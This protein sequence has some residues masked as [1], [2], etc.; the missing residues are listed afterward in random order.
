MV[1][2]PSTADFHKD[3]FVWRLS[4]SHI[5]NSVHLS[6]F[7]GYD[8]TILPLPDN[9]SVLGSY[10]SASLH[11]HDFEKPIPIKTLTPCTFSLTQIAIMENGLQAVN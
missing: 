1:I 5:Q 6:M 4:C 7:P 2:E 9:S 10:S 11:H 8:I 3:E